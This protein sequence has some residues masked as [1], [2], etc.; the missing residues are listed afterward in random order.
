MSDIPILI[1]I[2]IM[3]IALTLAI[4]II[5]THTPPD[6]ARDCPFHKKH[7]CAYVDSS[8]CDMQECIIL[9]EYL[10]EKKGK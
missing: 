2:I 4:L 5:A 6:P 10:K 8:W 7:G 1:P 9:K 3:L